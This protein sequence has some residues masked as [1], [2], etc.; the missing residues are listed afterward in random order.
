[1]IG[2]LNGNFLPHTEIKISP[3]DRGFLFADGVYEVIRAY[4]GKFFKA[5]EHFARLRRSLHEIEIADKDNEELREVAE[6]LLTRNGLAQCDATVYIQI[7][8]GAAPRKHAFPAS[9][10]RSTVY[11]T[12]SAFNAPA[13]SETGVRITLVPDIRWAR[14]DIKSIALTPNVLANQR[15]V[16]R[17]AEEAVFVREGVITEGSHSNFAAVFDGELVT[18]P[19]TNYILPGITREV[20]IRLCRELGIPVREFPIFERDLDRADEAMLL[21]TSNEVMPVVQVDDRQVL[22]GKPGAITLKLQRAFRA[23]TQL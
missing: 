17:N 12:A 1:M 9:S 23:L 19:K 18:H 20:T 8:R 13:K 3:D 2:Y 4:R 16:E 5:E 21:S 6:E 10:T 15:A 7:T 14:C 11:L 22:D